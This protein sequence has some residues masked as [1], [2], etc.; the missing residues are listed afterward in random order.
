M[1]YP[2]LE[3]NYDEDNDCNGNCEECSHATECW[4]PDINNEYE[5]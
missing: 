2:C 1:Q 5:N 4:N 3:D